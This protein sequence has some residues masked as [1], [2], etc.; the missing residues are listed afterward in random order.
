MDPVTWLSYDELAERLGIERESARTLVKRKRWARQPGN[1]GKV[2]IGVPDE[3]LEA[4]D[5]PGTEAGAAPDHV[6]ETDPAQPPAPTPDHVPVVVEVLTRHVERLE[7]AL[8][9]AHSRAADRDAVATERDLMAA[10]VEA[11]RGALEAAGLDRDRWHE[12]ATR[13]PEP[14][15]HTPWWK[16]LAG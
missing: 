2:R 3:C 8:E 6:P 11:L 13:A 12:L 14:V 7:A 1:D 15:P 16:R 9:E 4:R 5:V 10:Q